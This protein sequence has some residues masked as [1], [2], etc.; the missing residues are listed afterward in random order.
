MAL[1]VFSVAVE[2][3][4]LLVV[5]TLYHRNDSNHENLGIG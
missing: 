5:N 3:C 1:V 4:L 2:F